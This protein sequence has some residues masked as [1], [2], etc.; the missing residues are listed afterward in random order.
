M[1][2][3]LLHLIDAHPWKRVRFATYAVSLSFF[4][5][6]SRP[7][8]RVGVLRR[9]DLPPES[10]ARIMRIRQVYGRQSCEQA[11]AGEPPSRKPVGPHRIEGIAS[12]AKSDA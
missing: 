9:C 1:S 12:R 11:S 4:E 3:S 2:L 8:E 6:V 5:A 7:D 10:A